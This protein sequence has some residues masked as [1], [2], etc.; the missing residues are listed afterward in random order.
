MSEAKQPPHW[1]L[2][3]YLDWETQQ[4]IRYE[5]VDGQIHA[6]GGGTA[7]HDTIANNLRSELRTQMH[8]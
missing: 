4:P 1:T 7:E 3:A 2:D 5:L 8:G 6:I